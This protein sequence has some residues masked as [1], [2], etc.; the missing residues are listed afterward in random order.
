MCIK[1]YKTKCDIISLNCDPTIF[2]FFNYLKPFQCMN[3]IPRNQKWVFTLKC[4]YPNDRYAQNK[5]QYQSYQNNYR[6][7]DEFRMFLTKNLYRLSYFHSDMRFWRH[8][9]WP[10]VSKNFA[11]N[12]PFAYFVFWETFLMNC[13][14]YLR[15]SCQ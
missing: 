6:N 8:K 7:H 9:I 11:V 2:Y 12:D 3:R 1:W 4:N 15:H 14:F 10:L 13:S 5:N